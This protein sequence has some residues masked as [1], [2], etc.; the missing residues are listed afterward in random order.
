MYVMEEFSEKSSTIWS[1]RVRDVKNFARDGQKKII[2][3]DFEQFG[4]HVRD[5]YHR[6]RDWQNFRI[7]LE[8]LLDFVENGFHRVRD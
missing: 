1:S 8:N 2:L 5:E 6:V 7:F 3:R 4:H